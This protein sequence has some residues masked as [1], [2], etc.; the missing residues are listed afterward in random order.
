MFIV[1]FSIVP[2]GKVVLVKQPVEFIEEPV[3]SIDFGFVVVGK[4]NADNIIIGM[5]F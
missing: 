1:V 3:F 5:R 4:I 2:A